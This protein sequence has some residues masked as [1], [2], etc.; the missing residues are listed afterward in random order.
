LRLSIV[1]DGCG[2]HLCLQA[3]GLE[4]RDRLSELIDLVGDTPPSPRVTKILRPHG[5][6]SCA[7]LQQ[8]HRIPPRRYP[9]HSDDWE[10]HRPRDGV[11]LSQ[12]RGPDGRA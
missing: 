2:N 6:E 9:S 3:I 1:E 7:R 12:R 11:D 8:I 10:A 4:R 5:Y